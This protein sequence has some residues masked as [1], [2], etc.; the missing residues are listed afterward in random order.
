MEQARQQ[1]VDIT[2]FEDK[3]SDFK[4][5]FGYNYRLASEKFTKAIDEIDK[6]IQHLT[7]VREALVGSENN[8]RLAND[9]AEG[10]TIRKLT[11]QN[12]TMK[13]KFEEE[14]QRKGNLASLEEDDE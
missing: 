8:L 4:Q 6:T 2:N 9:K 11:Y 5:K 3:L 1:S 14:R 10:L 7:K 12:P 13:A